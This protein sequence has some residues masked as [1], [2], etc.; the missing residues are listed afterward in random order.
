MVLLMTDT[1]DDKNKIIELAERLKEKQDYP[2]GRPKGRL[3]A[4]AARID[5]IK[6]MSRE[7]IRENAAERLT[8]QE[9]EFASLIVNGASM[10][11]AYEQAFPEQVFKV[12]LECRH[13]GDQPCVPECETLIRVMS[14]EQVAA[15]ANHVSRKP[16]VRSQ[17]MNLLAQEEEDVSHTASRLDNFIVKSL[18]KEANNPL[19]SASARIAAL[20][21]LSE[22]RA[23]QVAETKAADKASRTSD[24]VLAA[25]QERVKALSGGKN[26]L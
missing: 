2:K 22:H 16:D 15:K 13:K 25:I 8:E 9:K 20:K 11:N 18:E 24:E 1:I 23:V 17:I 7:A 26:E 6:R 5:M 19:N 21:A 10:A 14:Y 12:A 3:G 4:T